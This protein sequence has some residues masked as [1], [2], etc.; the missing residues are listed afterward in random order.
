MTLEN[1]NFGDLSFRLTWLLRLERQPSSCQAFLENFDCDSATSGAHLFEHHSASR[2]MFGSTRQF[3][4]T[5]SITSTAIMTSD[6]NQ[7]VNIGITAVP[8]SELY[9]L[10]HNG[11][12]VTNVTS[13]SHDWGTTNPQLSC[14]SL[15]HRIPSQHLLTGTV[16]AVGIANFSLTEAEISRFFDLVK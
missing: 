13:D 11:G 12:F 4:P 14:F 2:I 7:F 3:T 1:V 10:Y 8:A 16:R 15:G 5:K 9:N 6:P